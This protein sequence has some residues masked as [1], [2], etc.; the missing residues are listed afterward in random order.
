MFQ[1]HKNF[2]MKINLLLTV[3]AVGIMI[4]VC[5]SLGAKHGQGHSDIRLW[6]N[7]GLGFPMTKLPGTRGRWNHRLS[8]FLCIVLC[9]L[10][11]YCSWVNCISCRYTQGYEHGLTFLTIKVSLVYI[12]LIFFWVSA[13]KLCKWW[14]RELGTLS[15]NTSQRKH[16]TFSADGWTEKQYNQH[17]EAILTS[18]S[19]ICHSSSWLR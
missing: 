13:V 7:G 18:L 1:V 4:C 2:P 12:L 19:S 11:N 14:C 5:H 17:G 6:M 9:F 15:L 16:W 8:P 3:M 10:L